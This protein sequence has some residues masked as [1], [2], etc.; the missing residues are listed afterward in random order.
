MRLTDLEY[1][2]ATHDDIVVSKKAYEKCVKDK[3][4]LGS[5]SIVSQQYPR[6]RNSRIVSANYYRE[7]K[8]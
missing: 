3:S 7:Y 4:S 6:L 2:N 5:N 8:Q 1:K